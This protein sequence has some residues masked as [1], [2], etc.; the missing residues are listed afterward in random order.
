[1]KSDY[2]N[3]EIKVVNAFQAY[4][5]KWFSDVCEKSYYFVCNHAV[6][7]HNRVFIAKEKIDTARNNRN[8]AYFTAHLFEYGM[9]KEIT[10]F[11]PD[12]VVSTYIY[13][14]IALNNISLCYNLPCKTAG[15]TLDYGVSP[16]WEYCA[17]KIDYMFITNDAMTG[18]FLKRG[19]KDKQ[20][21]VSGIPIAENF[22][23]PDNKNV[24][25]AKLKLEDCFTITVMKA[26]FFHITEE[27]LVEQLY[28][29]K[30]KCQVVLI[31]GNDEKSRK[32]IN[33]ELC[34]KK[35]KNHTDLILHNIGYTS[36]IVGYLSASDL[37]ICK[38]GGL[39]TTEI[40][41]TSVPALIIDRLPQQEIYN[42][43]YLIDHNCAIAV[44]ERTIAATINSLIDDAEK[45]NHMRE[46]SKKLRNPD[47]LNIIVNKLYKS[48]KA[49]YSEWFFSDS[50]STV[51]RIINKKLSQIHKSA[52]EKSRNK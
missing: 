17:D 6:E 36:D 21:I 27:K 5:S 16:Y 20:L 34:R 3:A 15:I 49:D 29:I 52:K 51:R 28:G 46:S 48:P 33:K 31:N 7:L 26:S 39:S 30:G 24:A 2:N 45:L 37:V 12:I 44:N 42:K 1:M 4:I 8:G 13:C 50:K 25:R 35:H 41:N 11:K 40:I 22:S 43:K 9:L 18:D 19:F 32:K 38:A 47:A 14:T 10:D 23:C